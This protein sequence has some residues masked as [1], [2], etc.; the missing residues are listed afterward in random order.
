MH[1]FFD[2]DFEAF[3]LEQIRRESAMYYGIMIAFGCCAIAC[4]VMAVAA[5]IVFGT[6]ALSISFKL[7]LVCL[8]F[9]SGCYATRFIARRGREAAEEM[10]YGLDHPECNIPDDYLDETKNARERA[11]RN[12]KSIKGLIISYTIIAILLWAVTV[13]IAFLGGIGTSGF[14]PLL[15][16]ASCVTFAMA[17]AL[18]ILAIAYITDLPAARR[19]RKKIDQLLEE[20]EEA[21]NDL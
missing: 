5:P 19:Y 15:L 2:R 3:L 9:A 1:Q 4:I 10:A 8:I 11:C 18:S 14:S 6:G 12:L 17:L 16:C 13:L 20:T 7:I 21:S